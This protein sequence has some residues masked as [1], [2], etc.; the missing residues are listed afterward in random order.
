MLE[1]KAVNLVA[2]ISDPTI[3]TTVA[4]LST[5]YE[6]VLSMTTEFV[7]TVERHYNE[8]CIYDEM[9]S[10]CVAWLHKAQDQLDNL[11]KP[12]T[13]KMDIKPKLQDLK[14]CLINLT[15]DFN[16]QKICVISSSV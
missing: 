2:I 11:A 15:V 12:A 16:K 9:Y 8:H 6:A 10:N 5:R 3:T 7:K 13:R 14:A 1:D 4:Q